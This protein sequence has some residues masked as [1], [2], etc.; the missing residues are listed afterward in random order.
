MVGLAAK[1][2]ELGQGERDTQLVPFHLDPD[3]L[4]LS[5]AGYGRVR[6][7]TSREGGRQGGSF[8]R[9]SSAKRWRVPEPWYG[10]ARPWSGRPGCTYNR[11][12]EGAL[13]GWTAGNGMAEPPT[14]SADPAAPGARDQLL[15]TKL[16]IPRPR[17]DRLTRSRLR[18]RLDEGLG[19]ALI[20][21]CT[22]AGFGKTT[23][24]ADWAAGTTLPVA[25]LSLDADDNDPARFC[26]T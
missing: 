5:A 9:R 22:P 14:S 25:W 13:A 4:A 3:R 15:A 8:N 7:E 20:L 21:V 23:L 1:L 12:P 26:A 16:S 19:Q 10:H 6:G 11:L 17:P 18:Q 24:L 2:D